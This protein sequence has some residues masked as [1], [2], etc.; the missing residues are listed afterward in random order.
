MYLNFNVLNNEVFEVAA[1]DKMIAVL[2]R[3]IVRNEG[4]A[5]EG[6]QPCIGFH[7]IPDNWWQWSD[8]ARFGY[9]DIEARL[10][11]IVVPMSG[12][13][14]IEAWKT[15]SGWEFKDSDMVIT[16]GWNYK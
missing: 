5:A 8:R 12:D 14:W 6:K 7:Y 2:E 1:D 4:L 9:V 3:N 16:N 15:D 13:T 10:S 11:G